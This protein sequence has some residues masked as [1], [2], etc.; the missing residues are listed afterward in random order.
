MVKKDKG[1]KKGPRRKFNSRYVGG[2]AMLQK[3]AAEGNLGER[4]DNDENN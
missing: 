4:E 3:I 1:L 2:I